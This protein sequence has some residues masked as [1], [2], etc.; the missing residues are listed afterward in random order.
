[1]RQSKIVNIELFK[2]WKQNKSDC[3]RL[4][5]ILS[6]NILCFEKF[7]KQVK[8]LNVIKYIKFISNSEIKSNQINIF[9]FLFSRLHGRR[10]RTRSTRRRGAVFPC[11]TPPHP[12]VPRSRAC[13]HLY[14]GSTCWPDYQSSW[15]LML[16]HLPDR[17][18]NKLLLSTF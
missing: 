14:V 8:V 10:S 2:Y 1:M 7:W 6:K 11:C 9:L 5:K 18:I 4:S 17:A 15:F 12:E 16:K 13:L 3:F